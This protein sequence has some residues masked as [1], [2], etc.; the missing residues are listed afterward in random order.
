M[1]GAGEAASD[2]QAFVERRGRKRSE[3]PEN[4]EA[5]GP[6]ANF[7]Q[8]ALGDSR[9]V[10]VHAE[11]EGSDGVNVAL[12]QALE[13]GG[14]LAGFIEAF[15]DVGEIGG[16]DGLHADENPFATARGDEVN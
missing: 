2:F 5:W 3:Q 16:V 11:D 12:G 4:G 6:G 10:V 1:F 15:V 8:G 13:Y 7:L 9:R 14:V